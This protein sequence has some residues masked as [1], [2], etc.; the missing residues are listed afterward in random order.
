LEYY[1][2][3]MAENIQ[4]GPLPNLPLEHYLMLLAGEVP[5][6]PLPRRG[7]DYYLSIMTGLPLG[8][9]LEEY[10]MNYAPGGFSFS[11]RGSDLFLSGKDPLPDFSLSGNDLV[12]DD[13][14]LPAGYSNVRLEGDGSLYADKG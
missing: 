10:L 2:R 14:T 13:G 5:V 7:L 1:F 11:I 12:Y 6:N 3:L 8:R 4:G 9:P